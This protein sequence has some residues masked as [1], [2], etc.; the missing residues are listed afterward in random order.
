MKTGTELSAVG[1]EQALGT[2]MGAQSF[3]FS[4][5]PWGSLAR[6]FLCAVRCLRMA[7]HELGS[8]ADARGL[9]SQQPGVAA[10]SQGTKELSLL[11]SDWSLFSTL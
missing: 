7:Q 6:R 1:S 11:I 9:C 5:G 4:T 3:P 2:E 8:R 10:R